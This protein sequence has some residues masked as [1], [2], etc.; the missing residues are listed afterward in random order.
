MSLPVMGAALTL[1]VIFP[2]DAGVGR[3]RNS[4]TYVTYRGFDIGNAAT[5][6]EMTAFLL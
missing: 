1:A 3:G 6:D 4:R 2:P 5:N